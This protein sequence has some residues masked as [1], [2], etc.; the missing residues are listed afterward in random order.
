MKGM[1]RN[2]LTTRLTA[3]ADNNTTD[4]SK[5]TQ[6]LI[7]ET[8]DWI[9]EVQRDSAYSAHTQG[10]HDGYHEGYDYAQDKFAKTGTSEAIRKQGYDDGYNDG[11]ADCDKILSAER[12]AAANY[13]QTGFRDGYEDGKHD[14][15]LIGHN[16]G[17]KEDGEY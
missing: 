13:Y 3:L 4:Q 17:F 9:F 1:D 14:G 2:E 7:D 6:T 10:H 16:N 5:S 12:A 8:V 15:L 11:H